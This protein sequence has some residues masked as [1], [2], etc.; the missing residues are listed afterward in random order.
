[1]YYQEFIILFMNSWYYQYCMSNW[2]CGSYWSSPT[3]SWTISLRYC[4]SQLNLPALESRCQYL[5]VSFLH[6]IYHHRTSIK[7]SCHC[8]FISILSTRSH[9]LS[10]SPPQSTINSRRYSFFVN[11]VCL[12]NSVPLHT[13]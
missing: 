2:I 13:Q 11:I 5:S 10:M 4:C 6:N 9:H 1:M 8:K 3:N 7:F 12:W